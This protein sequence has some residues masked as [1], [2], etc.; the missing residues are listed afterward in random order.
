M[1]LSITKVDLY[2]LIFTVNTVTMPPSKSNAWKYFKRSAD[3]KTVK[4]TLCS[5]E[6]TYTGGT[7]N[8]LNHLGL[9]HPSEQKPSNNDKQFSMDSFVNSP[10]KLS[11]SQSGKITQAIADMIIKDYVP[12]SIVESESFVNLMQIVAPDYK[13]PSRNT[14]KSRL[15][16]RYDDERDSL[17][18]E[19]NSVQSV[20]L[21]TDTWTSNATESY[22]TVTEHHITDDWE[23][24]SNVLMTRAMPERHTGENLANKLLD[25]ASEFELENKVESVVHDNAR[26]MQSASDKC[27]DWGDIGCFGHT[28]QLCVKPALEL[29][30]VSKIVSKC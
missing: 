3:D 8:M 29:Q 28:L 21:T 4:C 1:T 20:S 6:M 5:S 14:V 12:L 24:Q 9:K 2:A 18:K 22:I 13:V 25:C 11:S 17:V 23:M 19:L 10:K 16:K 26:N 15:I 30:N 27:E 7:T